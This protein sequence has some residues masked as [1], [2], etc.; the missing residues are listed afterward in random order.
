[1]APTN[2]A[3]RDDHVI[4]GRVATQGGS[5][6]SNDVDVVEKLALNGLQHEDVALL[7]LGL[8]LRCGLVLCQLLEVLL[9]SRH[10][11]STV[12]SETPASLRVHEHVH[13]LYRALSADG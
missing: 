3:L 1:M 5:V 10:E 12:H 11:L 8:V 13:S 7:Q 6:V 9:G 2:E 4:A